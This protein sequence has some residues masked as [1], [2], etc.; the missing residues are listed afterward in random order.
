[1][2]RNQ[3][4]QVRRDT[5][6]NWNSAQTTAGSS[7]LLAAGEIALETD[8]KK[9]KIGDG[10][11][12]WGSLPYSPAGVTYSSGT[13]AVVDRAGNI[14]SGTAG[15]LLYQS[16]ANT[17]AKLNIGSPGQSLVVSGANLPS[18][19]KLTLG[20]DYFTGSGTNSSQVADVLSDETGSAGGGV[21][22]FS[23]APAITNPAFS[24]GLRLAGSTSG[25][26]KLQPVNTST[27]S[28]TISFPSTTDTV[29]VSADIANALFKSGSNATFTGLTGITT[30]SGTLTLPTGTATLAV[31]TATDGFVKAD[32]TIP[33]GTTM[34]GNLP[35]GSQGIAVTG[36]TITFPSGS[37]EAVISG[38]SQTNITGS[39]KFTGT[40][41]ASST[42][43]L[44]GTTTVS[45]SVDLTNTTAGNI[46]LSGIK[47]TGNGI[48]KINPSTGA[49]SSGKVDLSAST[50][51]T[52]ALGA[53]NGG[54]GVDMT[55][56]SNYTA[57][58]RVSRIFVQQ[59][60]PQSSGG[61]GSNGY[62]AGYTPSTN[63]LW[64]W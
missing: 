57:G 13:N 54:L 38:V 5:A 17:T 2:A 35:L 14:G 29:V 40:F 9:F 10:V 39:K 25:T 31:S 52:N 15:D 60:A 53:V 43:T 62:I 49:L 24:N 32:G 58:Q 50:D 3:L 27:P 46:K 55:S 48:V 6:A 36:G 20:T 18:W 59:Y 56:S 45:G 7:P 28:G 8:T 21:V 44:S 47:A 26:L 4:I 42:T 12:L 22:V 51:V 64:F 23:N 41:E 11:T 19:S 33:S 37:G 63:D 30:S 16:G 61:V 34:T 1:M